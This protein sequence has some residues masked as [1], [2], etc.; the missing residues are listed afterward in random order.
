MQMGRILQHVEM[1]FLSGV[2]ETI[3]LLLC[4]STST[5]GFLFKFLFFTPTAPILC[6]SELEIRLDLWRILGVDT[7]K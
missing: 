3:R 7:E 1:S 5:F 2:S 6:S 4:M